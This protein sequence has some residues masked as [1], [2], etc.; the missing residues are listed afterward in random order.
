MSKTLTFNLAM[1]YANTGLSSCVHLEPAYDNQERLRFNIIVSDSEY[2]LYNKLTITGFKFV[3]LFAAVPSNVKRIDI[4][5][6]ILDDS[7]E[8]INLCG[9]NSVESITISNI[10]HSDNIEFACANNVKVNCDEEI[11]HIESHNKPININSGE[12]LM[13]NTSDETISNRSLAIVDFAD[14]PTDA[15]VEFRNIDMLITMNSKSTSSTLDRLIVD[16]IGAWYCTNGRIDFT[17]ECTCSNIAISN[18][19]GINTN[20]HVDNIRCVTN[21]NTNHDDCTLTSSNIRV[22]RR[23]QE[24][25]DDEVPKGSASESELNKLKNSSLMS[26]IQTD[27]ESNREYELTDP[28]HSSVYDGIIETLSMLKQLL[29]EYNTK[30]NDTLKNKIITEY[31]SNSSF[32]Y[33]DYVKSTDHWF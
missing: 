12:L 13:P 1:N 24:D 2:V 8:Y 32:G 7:I 18:V 26:I 16:N 29:T 4:N 3:D 33:L 30:P 9:S 10:T 5:D 31:L 19:P 27:I 20:F 15:I 28:D 23:W 21:F 11:H 14:L 17:S 6:L 22:A 25:W